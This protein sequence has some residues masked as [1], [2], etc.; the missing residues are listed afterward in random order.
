M[1]TTGSC[2][3]V[4][5]P[6]TVAAVSDR[7]SLIALHLTINDQL[8]KGGISY[9]YSDC[10]RLP[11][12]CPFGVCYHRYPLPEEFPDS[13]PADQDSSVSEIWEV[14][15]T[16]PLILSLFLLLNSILTLL[17]SEGKAIVPFYG[18]RLACL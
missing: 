16:S 3:Q 15:I 1:P 9:V 13:P 17:N 18:V 8:C 10:S 2:L 14:V 11:R 7:F 12:T 6:A 5:S 4:P